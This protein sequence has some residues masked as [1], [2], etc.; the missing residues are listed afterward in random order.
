MDMITFMSDGLKIEGLLD[1]APGDKGVVITH[2]HP[3][4][5]G[6]MYNYVVESIARIYREGNYTTLRFNFRGSGRSD[7]KYDNGIGE[8]NDVKAALSHLRESGFNYLCL[9]G[10]SFGAWVNAHAA[11][12]EPTIQ[13]MVVVSPP[14]A[15]LDYSD[16]TP[17]QKLKLVVTGSN[18][19]I[20]PPDIV[21]KM[22]PEWNKNAIVEIIQGAD[23]F[24]SGYL[25]ALESVLSSYLESNGK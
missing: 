6:D 14:V 22:I 24:Y 2:P 23:H 5:G 1:K 15:F 21:H 8:R 17:N 25:N 16:I 13:E 9:A 20:A 7:G 3:L 19:E 10:Y 4:Y 11:E 12:N 18:D